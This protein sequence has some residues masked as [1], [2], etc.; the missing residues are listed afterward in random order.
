MRKP[1]LYILVF[2]NGYIGL[3]Y[4]KIRIGTSQ[5]DD[6]KEQDDMVWTC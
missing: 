6:Q 2:C 1:R 4:F 5:S 3:N